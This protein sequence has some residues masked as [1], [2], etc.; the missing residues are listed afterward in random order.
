MQH[1]DEKKFMKRDAMTFLVLALLVVHAILGGRNLHAQTHTPQAKQLEQQAVAGGANQ[2]HRSADAPLASSTPIL[3]ANQPPNPAI[4]RW[5]S[6]GLEI[7]ASNSSLEQILRQVAAE[8]GAKLEGF[9]QDQRIFGSY[10]PG[11][12]CDV[13]SKLL[14]GS[15]YNVLIFG[16]HD[17][18][19]PLEIILSARSPVSPRMVANGRDRSS[20]EASKLLEPEHRP[21][22]S[23]GASS[24][25][26]NQDPYNV[27]GQGRDPVQSMQEIL[28]R[29]QVIDQQQE[30]QRNS[31][32]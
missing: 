15:G 29:Q 22:D 16:R 23:S 32:R 28:R 7:E 13:L 18:D 26:A 20:S 3:P 10:G 6:R 5:D 1:V 11:P 21:D 24:S 2:P 17:A 9:T 4:V 14:E 27:G 12:G 19:V 8:T 31:S 30:D 25:Q